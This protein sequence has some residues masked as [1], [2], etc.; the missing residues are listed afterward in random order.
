MGQVRASEDEIVNA[1]LNLTVSC[2]ET[3]DDVAK[4]LP[5]FEGQELD[6]K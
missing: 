2:T 4:R 3:W 1:I 6:E 5:K